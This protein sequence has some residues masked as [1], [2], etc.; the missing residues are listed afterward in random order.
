MIDLAFTFSNEELFSPNIFEWTGGSK[1]GS[2]FVSTMA[3]H[4]E[5]AIKKIKMHKKNLN[6][7][8]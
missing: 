3:S 8:V 2:Y 5:W 6:N 4:Y 1:L 7:E